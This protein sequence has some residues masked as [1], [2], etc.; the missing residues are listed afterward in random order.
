MLWIMFDDTC[1]WNVGEAL[2]SEAT[3]RTNREGHGGLAGRR[4]VG[5]EGKHK[6]YRQGSVPCCRWLG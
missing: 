2:Y 4:I 6:G 5:G 3:V 1:S